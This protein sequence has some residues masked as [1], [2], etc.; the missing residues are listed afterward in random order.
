[1]DIIDIDKNGSIC[2]REFFKLFHD[3]KEKMKRKTEYEKGMKIINELKKV[4]KEKNLDV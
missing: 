2:L 4:I 1:M 3:E